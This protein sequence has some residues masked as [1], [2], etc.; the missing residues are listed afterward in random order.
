MAQISFK[1][2]EGKNAKGPIDPFVDEI[3]ANQ[4]KEA[5][6]SQHIKGENIFD[7]SSGDLKS[8]GEELDQELQDAT[9]RD[10]D[11]MSIIQM[12]SRLE[13]D[14][15]AEQGNK[16]L[17]A[18]NVEEATPLNYTES[19]E[20]CEP[21]SD[22]TIPLWVRQNIINLAKEFGIHFNGCEEIAEEL[23]IKIDG[24]RQRTGEAAKALMLMT[25]KS[26]SRIKKPGRPWVV[27]G[28]FNTVRFPLEKRNCTRFNKAMTDFTDFI[29]DA[30]LVDIQLAGDVFTWKKGEGHDPAAR[31]DRFLISEEWENTFKNIKQSTL[32]R[33]ISDHCPLILEC[34]NW[35]RP[36]SY[37]KFENWW[38]QTENFKEMVKI[39]WDSS[40][41]RGKPD[42]ILASK[43]K[44]LKGK[45]KEWNRTRQGNLGLQKQSILNQLADLERIQDQRQLTDDESYLRAVLTT[46]FED[47]AKREKVAWRQRSR[48]LWLKEGDRNT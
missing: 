15:Y 30:E 25:P 18:V 12:D 26:K 14:T 33:V 6:A 23:F 31:L 37:F 35:E 27:E 34:G 47:N 10:D 21:T 11:A 36:N 9:H 8:E 39:W 22:S 7:T 2:G 5:Q 29:E 32:Q 42:F 1:E 40:I 43:L 44:Y 20:N 45:L 13:I 48:G 17:G 28:D 19:P 46:E 16:E 4:W 41:F 38:L 3:I 24:K